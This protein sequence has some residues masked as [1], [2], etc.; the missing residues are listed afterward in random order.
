MPHHVGLWVSLRHISRLRWEGPAH[1]G[2]CYPGQVVLDDIRKQ[3]EKAMRNKSEKNIPP[4]LLLLFL[5][6]GWGL[7]FLP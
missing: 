2:W 5:S 7:E 6:S 4:Q 3:V 1:G